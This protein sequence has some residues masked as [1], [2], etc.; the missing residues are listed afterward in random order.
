MAENKSKGLSHQVHL[1]K[2]PRF[3][4][5]REI[6]VNY[7]FHRQKITHNSDRNEDAETLNKQNYTNYTF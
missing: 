2:H 7:T 1:K 6:K 3:L 5:T 4:K